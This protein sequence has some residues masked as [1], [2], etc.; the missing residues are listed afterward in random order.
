LWSSYTAES[1][2]H[3]LFSAGHG[4]DCCESGETKKDEKIKSA[5]TMKTNKYCCPQ[6]L[7]VQ[8]DDVGNDLVIFVDFIV[9]IV[10]NGGI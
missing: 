1:C 10:T 3:H 6:T 2:F 9:A 7:T 4:T 8:H 5:F